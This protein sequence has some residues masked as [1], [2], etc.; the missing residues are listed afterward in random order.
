M[1]GQIK[2]EFEI[3]AV[4][5]ETIDG[6]DD[7]YK[8][9]QIARSKYLSKELTLGNVEEIINELFTEI[10]SAYEQPEQLTAKIIIRA[11]NENDKVMYL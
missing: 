3:N 4:G 7:S 5:E 8:N 10:Q 2:V 1:K 6:Y 9:Y 11:K